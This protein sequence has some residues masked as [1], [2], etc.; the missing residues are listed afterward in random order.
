[1]A[2]P[3]PAYAAA[4]IVIGMGG[5]AL[6]GLAFA[7]PLIVV[8][9]DGFSE[10]LT[11]D[12]VSTFLSQGWYGRGPGSMGAGSSAMR[13]AL[14]KLIDDPDLR[15]NLSASSRQLVLDRFSLK[16]AAQLQECCAHV[17]RLAAGADAADQRLPFAMHLEADDE[18]EP[19]RGGPPGALDVHA[20]DRGHLF[21]EQAQ[22]G[23]RLIFHVLQ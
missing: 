9:E 4:D 1:M 21:Q 18:I 19:L 6:R 15:K 14:Q 20:L 13:A 16:G 22:G 12:N 3:R 23:W 5:S 17:T 11:P 8:G 2:D 7:K 10:L